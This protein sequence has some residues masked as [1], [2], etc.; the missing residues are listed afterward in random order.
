MKNLK[1]ELKIRIDWSD[2][3]LF[4]HVNNVAFFKYIQASRVNFWE[5]YTL[6]EVFKK[7]NVGPILASTACQYKQP[8]FYPGDIIIKCNLVFTKTTS[9]GLHHTI[10][11]QNNQVAAEADDVIVWY[12]F[13][14][15]QKSELPLILSEE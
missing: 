10:L 14:K 6:D 8:L 7:T 4:G 3:D 11:N 13:N 15:N 9:F 12:D 5:K 1:S 2:M